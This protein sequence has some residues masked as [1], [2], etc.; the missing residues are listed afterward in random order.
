MERLDFCADPSGR[1]FIAPDNT[2]YVIRVF[3]G[4]GVLD[5]TIQQSVARIPKTEDEIQAEIDEYEQLAAVNP[6]LAPGYEPSPYHPLISLA[7]ID[8]E[9]NLWVRQYNQEDSV[10][11]DVFNPSGELVYTVSW[12]DPIIGESVEF[13]VDSYG[14]L[15]AVIDSDE[16]PRIY[17]FELDN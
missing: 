5:Q 2:E 11:F 10:N 8:H 15:G 6:S 7:G 17:R 16:Y 3:T 13:R 12:E 14:I 1:V 4:D 9:G